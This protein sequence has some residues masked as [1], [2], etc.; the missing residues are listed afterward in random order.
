MKKKALFIFFFLALATVSAFAQSYRG[1][2]RL[3]GVVLD[4]DGKPIEGV[5]VKLF[6]I[7]GQSGFEL[8]TNA[9][10]EWK[11]NYIRGGGWN[12]DFEKIGYM[13]KKISM[14][15]PESAQN[16][17]LETRLEKIEGLVISDEL[18]AALKSGNQLFDE[19]KYEE[20]IAAYSDLI[21]KNPDAYIINKNIGNCYFELQK[22]DKA[23]EAYRKVL[24]KEP[25]NAEIMLLI[26]NCY[27]N[28]GEK[29][30]AMEWYN[31]IEF[32]K[33]TDPTVLF[34]IGSVLSGQSKFEEA[35]KYYQRALDLK[36]DFLD[37]LYQLGL[38][39]VSLQ[40]NAAAVTAFENYL[41]LD[42]DSPKAAQVKGFLEYLKKK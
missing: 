36:K 18:K 29:D 27:S 13:P 20:A 12:I 25:Q 11:A 6:S 14:N 7:K 38:T 28:R 3:T 16:P 23:E 21:G 39:Y 31:K 37:A 32:D 1:Q 30:K 22:Y 9:K 24:D 8:V 41:K 33:I 26:G 40:N 10:G 2:G 34:N 35:L 5:K 4:R 19:K 42:A 15:I 17:T